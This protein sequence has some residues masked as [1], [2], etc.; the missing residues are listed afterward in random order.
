MR[1]DLNIVILSEFQIVSGRPFHTD[2]AAEEKRCATV[3][4]HD[5]GTVSKSISADNSPWCGPYGSNVSSI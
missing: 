3:L 4:V 5:L 1:C 2:G